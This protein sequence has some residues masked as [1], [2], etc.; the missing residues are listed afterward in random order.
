MLLIEIGASHESMGVKSTGYRVRIFSD[1]QYYSMTLKYSHDQLQIEQLVSS[2]LVSTSL[3][4]ISG[5]RQMW[6]N[7]LAILSMKIKLTRIRELALRLKYTH[8]W[9]HLVV[10]MGETS[11]NYP[12]Q[13]QDLYAYT[14][15][16]GGQMSHFV[17]DKSMN[18]FR[19]P[20][21]WQ[22]VFSVIYSASWHVF[23][24][25][26]HMFLNNLEP[27]PQPTPRILSISDNF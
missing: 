25:P 20:V 1:S 16:R 18:I 9:Q 13:R 19:L 23:A 5:V 10:L 11:H 6:A 17:N 24:I 21:G 12:T 26:S 27:N 15:F 4:S 22:Y 7:P 3:G 14:R 8:P 2:T